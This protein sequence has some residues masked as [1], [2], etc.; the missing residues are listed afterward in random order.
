MCIFPADDA[1]GHDFALTEGRMVHDE[2]CSSRSGHS[3]CFSVLQFLVHHQGVNGCLHSRM[4][5]R[6]DGY[7][8]QGRVYADVVYCRWSE[9]GIHQRL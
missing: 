7:T 8:Y 3:G 5:K 4:V 9:A 1:G 2:E 6:G